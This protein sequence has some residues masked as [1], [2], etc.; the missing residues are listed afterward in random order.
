M[1]LDYKKFNWVSQLECPR[2]V[3]STW[4]NLSPL[5]QRAILTVSLF[6]YAREWKRSG[7]A[8]V[9]S[10]AFSV[11]E[12]TE[13]RCLCDVYMATTAQKTS[14]LVK[15]WTN[16]YVTLGKLLSV[17]KPHFSHLYNGDKSNS[18][19]SMLFWGFSEILHLT[20][21]TWSLVH[22]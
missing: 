19:L 12:S 3:T 2:L 13:L 16:S 4:S 9:L 15:R 7:S 22:G 20:Y 8:E 5:S 6:T 10:L 11:P 18:F 17:T 21:L 1:T 14:D